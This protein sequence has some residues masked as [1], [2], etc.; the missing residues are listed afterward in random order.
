MIVRRLG[1]KDHFARLTGSF[2]GGFFYF[3]RPCG[4]RASRRLGLFGFVFAGLI[5]RLIFVSYFQKSL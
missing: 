3:F 5:V 1:S 2:G 4:Q